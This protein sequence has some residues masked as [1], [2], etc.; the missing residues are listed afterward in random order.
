MKNQ[1]HIK[2][3]ILFLLISMSVAA[4]GLLQGTEKDEPPISEN[5]CGDDVCDGPENIENCAED[6]LVIVLDQSQDDNDDSGQTSGL[7]NTKKFNIMMTIIFESDLTKV[8]GYDGSPYSEPVGYGMLDLEVSFPE[9]GGYDLYNAGTIKLTNYEEKGPY[10]TL[11][12]PEG[13]IGAISEVSWSQI[14]W[15]P[16]GRITFEADVDFENPAFTIIANCPPLSAPIEEYPLY[17]LLGIFNEEM[18]GFSIDLDAPSQYFENL[19]W[20]MHDTMQT[21]IDVVVEEIP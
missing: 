14:Y 1:S 7:G 21:T 19:H 3:I 8:P 18:R 2:W 20:G 15:D 17:K 11:E 4:C 12:T 10:C 5:R 16:Q 13:M 6:C 9:S